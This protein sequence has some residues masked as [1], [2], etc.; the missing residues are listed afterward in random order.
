[1]AKV[2]SNNSFSINM[3]LAKET[4]GALQ[5]KEVDEKGN[6]ADYHDAKIGTLYCR[7]SAFDSTPKALT[8]SVT[9]RA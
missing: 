1:M 7:K 8:V 4:K 2:Q 6:V 9:V 3:L 5:Y